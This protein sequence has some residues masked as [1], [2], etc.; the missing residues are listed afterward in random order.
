L[1]PGKFSLFD[2]ASLPGLNNLLVF[3]F[4]QFVQLPLAPYLH[5]QIA[6][7]VADGRRVRLLRPRLLSQLVYAGVEGKLH[8]FLVVQT[9]LGSA[10][11]VG[12]LD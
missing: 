8:V 12:R 4:G 11:V 6:H 3:I 2:Y 10:L 5:L 7:S 1:Y 9:Y